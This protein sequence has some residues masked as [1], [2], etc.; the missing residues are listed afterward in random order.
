MNN[1]NAFANISWSFMAKI[2]AVIF[3]F[4]TDIFIARLMSIEDYA[5]WTYFFS[6]KTMMIYICDLGINAGAKIMV[7]KCGDSIQRGKIIKSC[8][9]V[10]ISSAVIVS[11]VITVSSRWWIN[12]FVDENGTYGVLSP[13]LSLIG[14][15]VFSGTMLEFYKQLGYGIPDLK[16]TF[17]SNLLDYGLYFILTVIVLLTSKSV[18]GLGVGC[19]T[20]GI[21]ASVI[22]ILLLNKDYHFWGSQVS[23]EEVKEHEH[24][25][26]LNAIPLFGISLANL[27]AMELDTI[28]L[29]ILSSPEQVAI[30][31]IGKKVCS[32]APHVNIAI[33]AGIMTTFAVITKE[34]TRQKLRE[35][36]KYFRFNLLATMGIVLC[37]GLFAVWG[38]GIIYGKEYVKAGG[39]IICLL[40]YYVMFAIKVYM[41]LFLDFQNK[42]AMRS[43]IMLVSLLGNTVINYFLIPYYGAMGAAVSTLITEIPN[44]VYA[45][46]ANIK[47]WEKNI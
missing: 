23:H 29:G 25:V 41:S 46:G 45:M 14:F 44:F 43:I 8:L 40:P 11:L 7:S 28:M 21:L 30:Y 31:N 15:M 18:W 3:V 16:F 12:F 13:V 10:R 26:I 24:H 37:L 47:F 19:A 1:K 9:K 38:I 39:I 6:I 32:K 5:A 34:N 35:Y 42:L 22:G 33:S 27:M 4:L 17:K 20:A 2:V 36:K